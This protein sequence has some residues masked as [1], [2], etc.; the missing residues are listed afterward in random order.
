[1]ARH[2]RSPKPGHAE[3]GRTYV[4]GSDDSHPEP[5]SEQPR[6]APAPGIPIAPKEY[7][8]LKDEAKRRRSNSGDVPAQEDPAQS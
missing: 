1:M 7:Q 3:P 6:P 2:E 4:P 8:R 5:D